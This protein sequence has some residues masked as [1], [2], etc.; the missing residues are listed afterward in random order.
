[1]ENAKVEY[2]T[3][4]RVEKAIEFTSE[5]LPTSNNG[6]YLRAETERLVISL[7]DGRAAA[8]ADSKAVL[9]YNAKVVDKRN[10]YVFNFPVRELLED[11]TVIAGQKSQIPG[12]KC[13][14]HDFKRGENGNPDKTFETLSVPM[15]IHD[16]IMAVIGEINKGVNERLAA[17]A[18][19]KA[20]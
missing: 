17:Q 3:V 10:N 6:T 18:A 9:K 11:K 7:F 5:V 13:I 8:K 14:L 12:H 16:E 2:K 15:D 4:E 19:A 1:M 20:D